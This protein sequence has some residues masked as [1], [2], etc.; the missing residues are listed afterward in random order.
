VG[1]IGGGGHR[2]RAVHALSSCIFAVPPEYTT[3]GA[4]P[5][6]IPIRLRLEGFVPYAMRKLRLTPFAS[7]AH[8]QLSAH[9]KA[10]E[11]ESAGASRSEGADL[12]LRA[13][14]YCYAE[15]A[16]LASTDLSGADL[17]GAYLESADLRNARLIGTDL[18]FAGL[19]KANL[20]GALLYG[21]IIDNVAFRW[22]NV[23]SA[24]IDDSVRRGLLGQQPNLRN[25]VLAYYSDA[26]VLQDL[27]LPDN[28][29]SR[30]DDKDLSGYNFQALS[31]DDMQGAQLQGW[32]LRGANFSGVELDSANLSRSDL[33]TAVFSGARLS[34]ANFEGADLRGA[35]FKAARNLT[36][37]QVN[38]AIADNRTQLPPGLLAR[39]EHN[40]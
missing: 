25:W 36:Q 14:R 1:N 39:G 32:N 8:A 37:W 30:L 20:T 3:L 15:G 40:R 6:G 33:R 17:T 7:L 38:S 31:V 28:H 21:A 5:R 24:R 2:Q 16:L 10:I 34:N 4:G 35:N 27:H 18:R 12:R 29:N 22:T 13:L 26:G 19:W 9:E 11:G 23:Q